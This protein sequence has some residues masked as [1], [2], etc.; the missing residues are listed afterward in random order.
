MLVLP[1]AESM[2]SSVLSNLNPPKCFHSVQIVYVGWV[3]G[4]SLSSSM[5]GDYMRLRPAPLCPF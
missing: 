1:I 2:P 3:G 4:E 5:Y